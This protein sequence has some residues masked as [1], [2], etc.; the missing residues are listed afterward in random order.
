MGVRQSAGPRTSRADLSSFETT[1]ATDR[2]R[3]YRT[4]VPLA[5]FVIP[6]PSTWALGALGFAGVL[7]QTWRTRRNRARVTV[8]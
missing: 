7:T 6:E 1:S 3:V 8:A 2:Y 4:T 5:E